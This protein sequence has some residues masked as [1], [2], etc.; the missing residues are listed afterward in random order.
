MLKLYL[1]RNFA[2]VD[3]GALMS[4]LEF[5]FIDKNKWYN[6]AL[7]MSAHLSLVDESLEKEKG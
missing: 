2:K 7:Y 5:L 6:Y 1:C 4:A 3:R